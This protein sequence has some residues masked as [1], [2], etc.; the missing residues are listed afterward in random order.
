MCIADEVSRN[1][2]SPSN[3]LA[4]SYRQEGEL[5]I[6]QQALHVDDCSVGML[7]ESCDM[8]FLKTVLNAII[9]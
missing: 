1:C 2:E 5:K 6:M 8:A 4:P 9:F 3:D 7:I